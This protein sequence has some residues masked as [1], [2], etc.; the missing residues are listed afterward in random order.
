MSARSLLQRVPLLES[1][2]R[3]SR[4]EFERR[5]HAMPNRYK[6]ELIEGVVFVSSPVRAIHATPHSDMITWLGTYRAGTPGTD[7]ADNATDR[8]DESN[9][10]QPDAMLYIDVDRSTRMRLSA[11]GYLEGVPELI[12]EVSASSVS[13]DLGPKL[14]AYARNGVQE[15]LVW[16]VE[17]E[18][19]DWFT[20]RAGAYVPLPAESGIVRSKVFPGLWLDPAAM[21][22]R[23]IA[24]A[25]TVLQQGLATP[26]HTAF[27]AQLEAM[28]R[29]DVTG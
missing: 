12:A 16:R 2:D 6:A 22:D 17:D 9:E 13:K 24:R 20:L 19:I 4:E 14:T 7:V 11:D 29:R 10:P 28:P 25:L 15:Y 26:E 1:G 23:N 18:A 21:A 8:M 27:V 3:L 5:Y